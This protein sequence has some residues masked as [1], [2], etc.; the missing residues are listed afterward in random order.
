MLSL[1]Q[2]R[3]FAA[4]ADVLHF[5]KAAERC[6]VTQPALTT[7]IQAL[8][9]TLGVQLVERTRRRVVLTPVGV[10]I[11]RRAR[12]VL[13]RC[14]EI[15]EY[16][17]QQGDPLSGPLRFGV[18]PTIGPYVLPW[19]VPRVRERFPRLKLYLREDKTAD[20]VAHLRSGK[21]DLALLAL[22]VAADDLEDLALFDDPFVLAVPAAH[23]FAAR[24]IVRPDHLKGKAALLLDDGHCLRDQ[25]LEVCGLSRGLDDADLR[26]TSLN[27]LV[28]MV[29]NGLGMTLLPTL[30]LAVELPREGTIAVKNFAAPTP[31][32]KVG[33]LW[34]RSSARKADFRAL[35]EL[36]HSAHDESAGGVTS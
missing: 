15:V 22:P 21:I 35:G 36:I 10:E 17:R 9:A 19:L 3:Y 20:L 24:T 18:I 33:L 11:D 8:E 23:P 12:D 7:Q 30:S 5:R 29:A 4:L 34:R 2:L 16:A 26:A 25:A 31:A 27:T 13:R 1:R 32:R 14:D 28:H 6:H